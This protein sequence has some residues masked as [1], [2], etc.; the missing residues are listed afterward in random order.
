MSL[1]SHVFANSG[2]CSTVLLT[3]F[4]NAAHRS[5]IALPP[6]VAAICTRLTLN[7]SLSILSSFSLLFIAPGLDLRLFLCILACPTTTSSPSKPGS[8][9]ASDSR[10]ATNFLFGRR[11]LLVFA[12]DFSILETK[13]EC[14]IFCLSFLEEGKREGSDVGRTGALRGRVARLVFARIVVRFLPE[15]GAYKFH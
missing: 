9:S 10:L 5:A 4:F 6:V 8:A 12:E 1:R 13:A 3:W 11:R 14:L 2:F 15:V 7:L